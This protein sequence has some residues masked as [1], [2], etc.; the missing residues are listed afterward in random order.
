MRQRRTPMDP[1]YTKGFWP[2][3]LLCLFFGILGLHRFYTGYSKEGCFFLL[4]GFT[5]IGTIIS[6]PWALIDL[7]RILCR[8]YT[9]PNGR[10]LK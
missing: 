10:L 8:S 6:G 3:M 7:V 1:G 4:C 5:G 9:T 2:T